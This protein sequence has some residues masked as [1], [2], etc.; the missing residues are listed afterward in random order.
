MSLV[1]TDRSVRAL[2][3][4][5]IEQ[6]RTANVPSYTLAAEILLLHV[7]SQDRTWLYSH[8][9]EIL[10]A[11]VAEAYF[12]LLA[13]RASGVP[14]QHLTGKQEFWGLEFEVTPEVLIPRPETEHL[15]EVALDRLAVREI[16]AGRQPRLNGENVTL[17]D[18]GTGSGCIAITLAKELSASTVYATDISKPALEVARRNAARNGF[19][20]RIQFLESNLLEAFS[21]VTPDSTLSFDLIISNPPYVSLRDTDSLP[22]EVREH[23]PRIA[24]FGGEQG[25]ELYGALIPQAAQHLKPG[26]QLILEL[27]YNSLPAV[28]PLLDRADWVGI[29]VTKDLAGIP[30]VISAERLPSR[31][32]R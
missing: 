2:L 27:G 9:E 13:R 1:S 23:E 29:S 4:Q 7:T 12:A 30:R 26:G 10:L 28:E 32:H 18:I 16:R 22:I 6:L 31:D 15:I 21:S 11:P 17:V 14:T 24:L 5:G 8:P 25:Y 3:K 19:A 20:D